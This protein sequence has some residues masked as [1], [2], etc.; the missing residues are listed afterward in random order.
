MINMI[1][2]DYSTNIKSRPYFKGSCVPNVFSKYTKKYLASRSRDATTRLVKVVPDVVSKVHEVNIPIS[3]DYHIYAWDIN[4]KNSK[5]YVLFLHGLAMNISH[6]QDFYK[7]LMNKVGIFAVE[8]TGYGK[9]ASK[10]ASEKILYRDVRKAYEYL[11]KSKNIEPE[12]IIVVGSCLGGALAVDLAKSE[13]NIKSMI[14]IAPFVSLNALSKKY[15]TN[16]KIFNSKIFNKLIMNNKL[17]K[18]IFSRQFNVF[19]KMKSIR[20]TET[21][22]IQSRQDPVTRIGG[23]K[24]LANIASKNSVL[25]EFYL[26]E[27]GGHKVD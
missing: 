1:G 19:N 11:I 18:W 6:Y 10:Q 3:K 24:I 22:L 26:L 20:N 8:Y 16:K 2:S 7:A 5:N 4:P 25:K 9:N 27:S 13:K 21:Y 17:I 14:L 12:K 15:I 23:A